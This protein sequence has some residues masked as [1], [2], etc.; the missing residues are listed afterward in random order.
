MFHNAI[1]SFITLRVNGVSRA[2]NTFGT[3]IKGD[4]SIPRDN[5]KSYSLPEISSFLFTNSEPLYLSGIRINKSTS[6]S[7]RASPLACEPYRIADASGA[8]DFN[9]CL[10]LDKILSAN[11]IIMLIYCF[12]CKDNKFF[13]YILF[14][15]RKIICSFAVAD[16]S[17]EAPVGDE[18]RRE[19]EVSRKSK[20]FL[21]LRNI[22]MN[23]VYPR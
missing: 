6:E 4:M 20:Q 23:S 1:P 16:R 9:T 17:A 12:K 2:K 15:C 11:F 14:E 7:C 13:L 18:V 22:Y 3:R 8:A 5:D 19:R 21:R 10:I